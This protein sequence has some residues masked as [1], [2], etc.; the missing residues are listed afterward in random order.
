MN[1]IEYA[2]NEME[3]AWPES[4]EKLQDAM[5]RV[6]KE[7]ILELITVFS[8]Q[9]HSGM[10]A[11]YVLRRFYRLANGLPLMP[12]T[13][14]DDEWDVPFGPDNRQQNKRCGF[15]FRKNFDNATAYNMHGKMLVDKDGWC[16]V[17]RESRVPITFPYEVPDHPEYIY[18]TDNEK[19]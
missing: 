1:S 3:R 8:E 9:G 12:L 4:G 13:G 2:K 14:E 15:I 7:N 18:E 19:E 11:N 17:T 5:Q 10:S 6:A 16:C